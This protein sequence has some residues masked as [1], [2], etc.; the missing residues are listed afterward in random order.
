MTPDELLAIVAPTMKYEFFTIRNLSF[1]LTVYCHGGS[2][3]PYQAR[4]DLGLGKPS[5]SRITDA[6]G[7]LGLVRRL[8]NSVDRR[9]RIV[10]ITLAGRTLVEAMC[11][12]A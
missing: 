9:R 3:D 2:I 12:T 7:R 4:F 5:I 10:E 8:S 1:L 11:E 6:L